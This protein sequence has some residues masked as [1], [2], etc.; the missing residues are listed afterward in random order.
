MELGEMKDRKKKILFCVE[1]SI[2]VFCVANYSW[3]ILSSQ[4][5]SSRIMIDLSGA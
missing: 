2:F 1:I 4:I 3:G 5:L